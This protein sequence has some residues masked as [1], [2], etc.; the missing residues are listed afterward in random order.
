MG[1]VGEGSRV[2]AD[3]I[4]QRALATISSECDRSRAFGLPIRHDVIRKC[5]RILEKENPDSTDEKTL[6]SFG[7]Q[8]GAKMSS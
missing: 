3:E 4:K 7:W 6:D 2:D 1:N 5:V 8:L